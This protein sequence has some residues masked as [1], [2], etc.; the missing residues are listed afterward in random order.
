MFLQEHTMVL[1]FQVMKMSCADVILGHE[2]LHGLGSSLHRSYEHNTITFTANG[3]HVLLI[4]ERNV[5]PTPLICTVEI[6]FLERSNQIEEV[7]FCYYVSQSAQCDVDDASSCN[8]PSSAMHSFSL[9]SQLSLNNVKQPLNAMPLQ[10]MFYKNLRMRFLMSYL[11]VYLQSGLCL[12][13]LMSLLVL[14]P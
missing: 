6:S 9:P 3:K 7:Y 2:W 11:R 10:K 13:A 4:G 12:I 8:E 14:N 5:P 1:D